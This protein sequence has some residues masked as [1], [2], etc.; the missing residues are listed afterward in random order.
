MKEP[1]QESQ[2]CAMLGDCY[3]WRGTKEAYIM[4]YIIVTHDKVQLSLRTVAWGGAHECA[5]IYCC[6]QLHKL[7]AVVSFKHSPSESLA[8]VVYA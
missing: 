2:E 8:M 1:L 4:N 7:F 5:H 6:S 3:S